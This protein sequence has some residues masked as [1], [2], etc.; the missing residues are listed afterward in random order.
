[1]REK[2]HCVICLKHRST[3][4]FFFS[5]KKDRF[6]KQTWRHE[7]ATYIEDFLNINFANENRKICQFCLSSIKKNTANESIM[8]KLRTLPS[9]EKDHLYGSIFTLL[10]KSRLAWELACCAAIAN[11]LTRESISV[12]PTTEVSEP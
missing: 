6:S 8:K 9:G 11:T 12:N 2:I 3:N 4:S 10:R 1:M 5:Y 7:E